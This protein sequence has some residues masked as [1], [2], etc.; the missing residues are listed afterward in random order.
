[1]AQ[2]IGLALLEKYRVEGGRVSSGD[3]STYLVPTALDVCDSMRVEFIECLS[4]DG[5]YGAKGL[6]EPAIIPVAAAIANAVSN[7][8]DVRITALPIE[9]DWIVTSRQSLGR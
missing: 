4:P 3:L 6:G 8:L 2:G 1:V 7:A 5:P 9:P